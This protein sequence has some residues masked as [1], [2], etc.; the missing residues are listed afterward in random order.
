MPLTNGSLNISMA[1]LAPVT[2]AVEVFVILI[3]APGAGDHEAVTSTETNEEHRRWL[4]DL[5][6][7]E[8]FEPAANENGP[9][10]VCLKAR[11]ADFDA[12]GINGKR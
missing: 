7:L 12:D 11:S 6:H 5:L 1:E 10:S 8:G 3:T 2:S 9:G 4:G